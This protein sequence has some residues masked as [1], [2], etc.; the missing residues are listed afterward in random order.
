MQYGIIKRLSDP[1]FSYMVYVLVHVHCT[2]YMRGSVSVTI[3]N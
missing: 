3:S 1:L 2:M